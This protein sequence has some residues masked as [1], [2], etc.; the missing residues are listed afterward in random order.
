[1][2]FR[3]VRSS[4]SR[5]DKT[6]TTDKSDS[7]KDKED[8]SYTLIQISYWDQ[9]A[10]ES[11][12]CLVKVTN[13]DTTK[14]AIRS[15]LNKFKCGGLVDEFQLWVKSGRKDTYQLSA[16]DQP[17]NIKMNFVRDRLHRSADLQTMTKLAPDNSCLF[18]LRK[19]Y[20]A[21]SAST[22]LSD[23]SSKKSSV[24]KRRPINWPF[25]KTALKAYLSLD[26]GISSEPSTPTK[27][28]KL[29]GQHL[30][31]LCNNKQLPKP[32]MVSV[33]TLGSDSYQSPRKPGLGVA[34]FDS[35]SDSYPQLPGMV[36]AMAVAIL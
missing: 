36:R 17:F 13:R 29:F 34:Y 19:C 23:C 1:M 21:K 10:N 22:P 28:E 16:G 30:D 33:I 4:R 8:K 25:K 27:A 6:D 32:L 35:Y 15:A 2:F 26:S 9:S 7:S 3:I 12:S 14:E 18:I 11:K 24:K 5:T 20:L 31:L